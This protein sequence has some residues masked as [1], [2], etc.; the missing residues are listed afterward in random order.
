MI[1]CVWYPSGGFGHFVN[2]VLTLHGNNFI[3]PNRSLE[4]SSTGD[5]HSL[6]LIVPKYF[7]GCWPGGIDFLNDK[8]YCVLIDNGINNQSDNF[9]ATFSNATII[10][11][12]YSDSSWP[13]VAYTMIEK[14]MKSNI[15]TQ[16]SLSDWDTDEPWVQREKY[17]LYLRDHDLRFAWRSDP[18]HQYNNLIYID[19]LIESYTNCFSILNNIIELSNFEEVWKEWHNAN[20][21]YINPVSTAALVISKV[22]DKQSVDLKHI[23]DIWTQAVIYYYIWLNFNIE[24]PHNDFCNFF[25]NTD[26]IVE[27]VS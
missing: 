9:K 10:K 18:I 12:C 19:N 8:N 17:F 23:T 5:S 20:A 22:F 16:L 6:D 1:Y 13:V 14:A 4:F 24:V 26:Q 21:K 2:A 3:R 11:I 15:N 7:H 25:N 27:L